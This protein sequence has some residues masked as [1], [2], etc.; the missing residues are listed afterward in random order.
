MAFFAEYDVVHGRIRLSV[1]GDRD[2]AF[3][4][5]GRQDLEE[6]ASGS[7]LR[8]S[9]RRKVPNKLEKGHETFDC[10]RNPTAGN[11]PL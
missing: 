9:K 2:L 5:P 3:P 7:R 11:Q 1:P 6:A 8:G 10:C 4:L